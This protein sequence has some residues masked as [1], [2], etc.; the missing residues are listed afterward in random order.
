MG[1]SRPFQRTS[2]S[3][4]ISTGKIWNFFSKIPPDLKGV[5]LSST[6]LRSTHQFNTKGSLLFSPQ[7]PSVQHQKLLSSTPKFFG[8]RCWTEECVELRDFGSGPCVELMYWTEGVCVELRGT[9]E[10]VEILSRFFDN[11]HILNSLLKPVLTQEWFFTTNR[12]II[13]T[14]SRW[15]LNLTS[16]SKS[17][18]EVA[19]LVQNSKNPNCAKKSSAFSVPN[20]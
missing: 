13:W 2:K 3:K 11:F 10:N 20:V 14:S 4:Y 8:I 7:N 12:R 19:F 15:I 17:E 18:T 9:L 16:T 6:P 5:L 1:A